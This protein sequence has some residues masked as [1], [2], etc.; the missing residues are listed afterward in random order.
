MF[1]RTSSCR[2]FYDEDSNSVSNL[3][4]KLVQL[5]KNDAETIFQCILN[6]LKKCVIP[7]CNIIGFAADTCSVMMGEHNSVQQKMKMI[8]PNVF[9][10]GCTCHTAHLCTSYASKKLP[11]TEEE[12]VRIYSYFSHSSKRQPHSS[13]FNISLKWNHTNC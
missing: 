13:S 10:M 3:L 7:T 9:I 8:L 6:K 4:Y 11:R 1:E 5:S 2:A 12:L